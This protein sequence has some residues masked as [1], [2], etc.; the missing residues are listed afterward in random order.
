[1]DAIAKRDAPVGEK[2]SLAAKRLRAALE[3]GSAALREAVDRNHRLGY[4]A[5][6]TLAWLTDQVVVAAYRF[7]SERLFPLVSPTTS[8]RAALV[9]VGGY[10]RGELA[11]FSDVDLLFLTPY[12][13]TAWGENVIETT[14]YI[15]WDLKLKVGHATRSVDECVRRAGSDV[16]IRTALLENRY[17]A[18]SKQLHWELDDRLWSELFEGTGPEFV[19]AKLAE[20]DARHLRT[21]GSRYLL[22]PNVKESKGGLRDLQTIFWLAKYLYRSS[23]SAALAAKGVFSDEEATRCRWAA[24]TLWT[25]RFALHYTAGRAQEKLTFDHQ[26]ELAERFG[27]RAVRGQRPVER[28]MKRYFLAAKAVGDLTAIFCAALEHEHKKT[29]PL[30]GGLMRLLANGGDQARARSLRFDWLEIVD[31]RIG[32]RDPARLR[33]QPVSILYLFAEAVRL[34]VA[35]HPAAVREV[36]QSRRAVDTAF[37]D[38]PEAQDLFVELITNSRDPARALRMLH[39]TGVLGRFIPEFGRVVGLMQFNMYHHYTVDEHSILA[40]ETFYRIASGDLRDEHPVETEIAQR[41]ADRRVIAVTLL[42]HDIGKGLPDDH[43]VAG[44]RIAR[45][46]CPAL[47]MTPGETEQVSWL[48]R[49]HLAMSNTA[50]KRDLAEPAT[51]RSFAELVRSPNRLRLLYVLTACDI[52]AVGPGVWNGW[53][54]QLLRQLYRETHNALMGEAPEASRSERV[55]EAKAALLAQLRAAPGDAAA[56]SDA[57]WAIH[58]ERFNS[59]YWSTLPTSSHLEHAALMGPPAVGPSAAAPPVAAP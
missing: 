38:S 44:A 35:V 43:S 13:Q 20:R 51:I 8:E 15:L 25:V 23:D 2:R 49:H 36:D 45:V 57:A 5:A 46:V 53:K 14:L 18:G 21:G 12:K 7:V 56:W 6:V 11:P 28:F 17:L 54:A 26:I 39:V 52:R 42:L 59:T 32:V 30:L 58:S 47:G 48:I 40:V 22:E 33:E 50:Q 16:T 55:D 3:D 9:A 27:Y 4:G 31:G 41:L 1:L 34:G 19:D 10:G 24:N 29:P 37:R